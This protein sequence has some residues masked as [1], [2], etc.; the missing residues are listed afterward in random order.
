MWAPSFLS[1]SVTEGAHPNNISLPFCSQ[2][3]APKHHLQVS[4][5]QPLKQLPP[6]GHLAGHSPQ[7]HIL[8]MCVETL[9]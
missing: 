6:A 4:Y 8:C 2:T 3:L 9:E 7:L 5:L 1:A